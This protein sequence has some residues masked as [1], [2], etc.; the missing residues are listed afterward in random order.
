MRTW[1]L[2]YLLFVLPCPMYSQVFSRKLN[3]CTQP[4]VDR[5]IKIFGESDKVRN[6]PDYEHQIIHFGYIIAVNK[7]DFKITNSD[8]LYK[9]DSVYVLESEPAMG[10]SLGL[11][12][13]LHLTDNWDLRF[14]PTLVLAG[15]RKL[16]YGFRGQPTQ[17]TNL[18]TKKINSTIIDFPLLVK[19]K[20]ARYNNFRAYVIGGAKYSLDLASNK[21]NNTSGDFLSPLV[22]IN[23]QDWSLEAGVGMDFYLEYFKFSTE[24]RM[25][26]G[27]TNILHTDTQPIFGKSIKDMRTNAV[28]LSFLFE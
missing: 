3:T 6:L 12:A 7:Y 28:T 11:L 8:S 13:N 25:S 15:T 9:R 26:Y 16:N 17:A 2:L 23:R 20:S 24:L 1:L 18:V 5:R 21:K 22:K 27:Q 10:F 14:C 4:A 19:F